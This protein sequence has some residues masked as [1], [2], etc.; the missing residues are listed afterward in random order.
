MVGHTVW[1]ESF[2]T[3]FHRS[4]ENIVLKM[5]GCL[6]VLSTPYSGKFNGVT[7]TRVHTGTKNIPSLT[8]LSTPVTVPVNHI[9]SNC[10]SILY[11]PS[12]IIPVAGT[13]TYR[14][15][16]E[17]NIGS[18]IPVHK[19]PAGN[20]ATTTIHLMIHGAIALH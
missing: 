20:G 9:T 18:A 3:W 16:L 19:Q 14:T 11:H 13:R 5:F 4:N 17:P 7:R 6:M 8:L 2:A 15:A 10:T 12:T 1:G